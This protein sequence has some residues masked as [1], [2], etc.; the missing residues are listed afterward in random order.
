MRFIALYSFI[1]V[2]HMVSPDKLDKT[3]FRK[4]TLRYYNMPKVWFKYIYKLLYTSLRTLYIQHPNRYCTAPL[5]TFFRSV[6]VRVLNLQRLSYQKFDTLQHQNLK[7]TGP[8]YGTY[9]GTPRS[10]SEVHAKV[11]ITLLQPVNKYIFKDQKNHF[12][13]LNTFQF[14]LDFEL[15]LYIMFSEVYFRLGW[16]NICFQGNISIFTYLNQYTSKNFFYCGMHSNMAVFPQYRNIHI[17][18][19][20]EVHLDYHIGIEYSVI[21]R[22]IQVSIVSTSASHTERV[23]P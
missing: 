9:P 4:L 5:S 23:K 3:T 7:Y 11:Y 2:E 8:R 17:V 15:R 1:L 10:L 19:A 13:T 18:A 6:K 22:D 14:Y 12:S 16:Q 20:V 21:D